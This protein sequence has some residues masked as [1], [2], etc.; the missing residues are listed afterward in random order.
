MFDATSTIS[1]AENTNVGGNPA[2]SAQA[3]YALAARSEIVLID[4]RTQKEWCRTGIPENAHLV[5]L[6]D[7]RTAK[8]FFDAVAAE[9]D[10]RLDTPV[11]LICR[12]GRRTAVARAALLEGGFNRVLDV[13]EGVEGGPNGRGW[14][15]HGLPVGDHCCCVAMGMDED[16]CRC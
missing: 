1:N 15:A 13:A 5:T 8:G 14:L 11:A 2:I 4:I 10:G 6:M 16:D 3:A 9:L 7:P 12:T